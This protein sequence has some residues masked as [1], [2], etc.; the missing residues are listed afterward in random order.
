MGGRWKPLHYWL[1]NT[2]FAD[3]MVAC[4]SDG[5]CFFKNDLPGLTF[6]GVVTVEA[7][8]FRYTS[9]GL[10]TQSLPWTR[11]AVVGVMTIPVNVIGMLLPS[12]L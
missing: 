4:G 6:D 7:L 2:A 3:V 5:N 9:P 10:T 1:K 11:S 12:L 8:S